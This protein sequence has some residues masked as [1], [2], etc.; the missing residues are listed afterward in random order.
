MIKSNFLKEKKNTNT[1]LFIGILLLCLNLIQSDDVGGSLMSLA[2]PDASTSNSNLFTNP[3][4]EKIDSG[5][6]LN[7]LVAKNGKDIFL[8]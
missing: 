7:S 5:D 6:A 1:Y 4:Q 2:S 8:N 3:I